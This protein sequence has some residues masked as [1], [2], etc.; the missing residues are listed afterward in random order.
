[1]KKPGKATLTKYDNSCLEKLNCNFDLLEIIMDDQ[2]WINYELNIP[3]ATELRANTFL[4]SNRLSVFR[5]TIV[6]INKV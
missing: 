6:K 1:M 4:N 2:Q 3:A 5:G